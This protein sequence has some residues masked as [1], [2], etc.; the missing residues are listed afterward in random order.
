MNKFLVS[1]LFLILPLHTN[2][3]LKKSKTGVGI[4]VFGDFGTGTPEQQDVAQKMVS[5]CQTNKCDFALT[6]GDNIYKNGI[7]SAPDGTPLYEIVTER[8]VKPYEALNIPI[9][10]TLGNHD[11]NQKAGQ[12]GIESAIS[13]A[14]NFTS[15]K[16]N[17][18]LSNESRNNFRLWNMNASYY[19]KKE[20]G[21]INIYSLDTNNFPSSSYKD[22]QPDKNNKNQ[23]E[24]LRSELKQQNNQGWTIV[25]GHIPLVSHGIHAVED[26]GE[27]T[28]I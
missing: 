1:F 5:Y 11:I 2:A 3:E 4:L 10:M 13:N 15:H 26:A 19:A 17:P 24:W 8:F 9:Y 23:L 7:P 21:D 16:E 28:E 20:V 27:I 22:G 25:F 14:I 18:I 12:Q 6:T